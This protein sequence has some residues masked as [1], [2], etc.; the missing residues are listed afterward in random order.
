MV[1]DQRLQ[2]LLLEW[3]ELRDAGEEVSAAELCRQCPE[4]ADELAA[5]IAAL[6]E[7]DW[8]SDFQG[9]PFPLIKNY[10]GILLAPGAEP[11]SG[12]HLVERLGKGGFGEVWATEAPDGTRVALKFVPKGDK[13]A[14]IEG[15]ALE[16]IQGIRHPNLSP[17][18][19]VWQTQDFLLIAMELADGT[20]YDAWLKARSTGLPGIPADKLLEYFRQAANGIDFLHCHAIQHRDIKP[21]NLLL[22]N[23]RVKVADFGLA[24]ILANTVTG[25]TG[26][27]TVAF[28]APEFFDGRTTRHSDQYSLAVAYC[29]LRGGRLPFEGTAAAI[30]AGHLRRPPDLTMLPEAEQPAVARALSKLPA[31]RWPS[32]QAFVAAIA[33][34]QPGIQGTLSGWASRRRWLWPVVFVLLLAGLSAALR[35]LLKPKSVAQP[36]PAIRAF[37][38][39]PAGGSIRCVVAGHVASSINR[40]VALSNGSSGILLWDVETGKL[41]DRLPG[42]GGPCAALAPFEAPLAVTGDDDGTV[43][44][45]DLDKRKEVRRFNGHTKS[46]SSATFSQDGRR[47]LTGSCDGTVRLWN[48]ATGAQIHCMTGHDGIVMGTAIATNGRRALSAGW[49]GTVTF[50]DME[51]GTPLKRLQGH[52]AR[53]SAVA[54]SPDGKYAISGGEDRVILLWDLESGKELR[55]FPGQADP[56]TSLAF[57]GFDTFV[58][59]GDSTARLWDA[60]TGVELRR[61]PTLSSE[62]ESS[63]VVRLSETNYLLIGTAAHGIQLWRLPNK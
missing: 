2:D 6:Q 40:L 50:W 46:V 57:L 58:S 15:R 24:R 31:N 17:A 39:P 18:L 56:V 60:G 55:R 37:D 43:V 19:G 49:D 14:A 1:G 20:L 4:L 10:Q 11:I 44:L 3:E 47:L 32:C 33:G 34:G 22:V 16:A 59:T 21:Q 5:R 27:L 41:I 26:S 52:D 54:F 25:H 53:L 36:E 9:P 28:A 35:P 23:N 29:K 63:T 42:N 8:L 51:K 7:M 38:R 12:Y 13:A 30:M 62:A 45:W 48:V 61:S